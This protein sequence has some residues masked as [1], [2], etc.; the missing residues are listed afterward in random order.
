MKKIAVFLFIIL[1]GSSLFAQNN[2][3][4]VIV[5]SRATDE[6][7]IK[8]P[9]AMDEDFDNVKISAGKH[10]EFE[11]IPINGSLKNFLMQL[12]KKGFNVSDEHYDNQEEVMVT[13][14]LDSIRDVYVDIKYDQTHR[15][16]FGV[17]TSLFIP[18]GESYTAIV[19][20]TIS[21]LEDI[22]AFHLDDSKMFENEVGLRFQKCQSKILDD[23]KRYY[24]GS[25]T[26]ALHS[27]QSGMHILTVE[28]KDAYNIRQ[29]NKLV[30]GI[31]D[32]GNYMYDEYFD[33]C[34]ME[35]SEDFLLFT[36]VEKGKTVKFY[37]EDNDRD[38]LLA[39][40]CE[41][42]VNDDFKK[43]II[44][45]YVYTGIKQ[46][47]RS[48]MNVCFQNLFPL[49]VDSYYN[50]PENTPSAQNNLRN[51]RQD[52]TSLNPKDYFWQT[53]VGN[54]I[55]SKEERKIF[56]ELGIY[57]SLMKM[58]PRI[59]SITGGNGSTQWDSYNDAQKGVIHEHDNAR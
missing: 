51:S 20:E 21:K 30:D 32:L 4:N 42:S 5:R 29:Q 22:Y 12:R 9:R 17:S 7:V 11:G 48:Q 18:S 27:A 55:F 50:S 8:R 6:D 31:F 58:I 19:N 40:L 45:S 46:H 38:N 56:K 25:I 41:E 14:P 52:T 57:P 44:N 59:G 36:V 26:V 16:V 54:K 49:T 13:F 37:A 3:G 33:G 15:T 39:M 1:C 47:E 53:M 35:V 24:L 2:E 28:Y 23:S 10:L 34:T 43:F